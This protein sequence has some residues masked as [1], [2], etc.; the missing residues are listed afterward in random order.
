M[1]GIETLVNVTVVAA[2]NRPDIIVCTID[3]TSHCDFYGLICT[4]LMVL[5]MQDDAL[6]RPGRIDRILYVGPPDFESRK[7]IFRIQVQRMACEPD[8]IL[9]ELAEQ[10]EG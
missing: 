2:T 9:D 10:S 4:T 1:D 7:E 3:F 5:R 8:V 6:L